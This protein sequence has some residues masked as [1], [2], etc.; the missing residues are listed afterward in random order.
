MK[1]KNNITVK[2]PEKTK[3]EYFLENL[4]N[5][6]AEFYLTDNGNTISL[7]LDIDNYSILLHR[8]GKY[9]LE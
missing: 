8:N 5:T 2:T 9:E 3:W 7:Y 6:G 1:K 4:V